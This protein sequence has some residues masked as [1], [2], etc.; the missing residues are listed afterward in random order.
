MKIVNNRGPRA[1]PWKTPM[2]FWKKFGTHS[3]AG[4]GGDA[5]RLS[6][7]GEIRGEPGRV[8][9]VELEFGKELRV[10]N[11]IKTLTEI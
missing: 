9:A 10:R 5:H 3:V 6:M 7:T 4:R 2:V 1:D 8:D 11:D